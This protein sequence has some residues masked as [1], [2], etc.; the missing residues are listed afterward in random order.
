MT[1]LAMSQGH[2]GIPTQTPRDKL[3]QLPALRLKELRIDVYDELM[4]RQVTGVTPLWLPPNPSYHVRR[5]QARR[6]LSTLVLHSFRHLTLDLVFELERRFPY[7]LG[8]IFHIVDRVGHLPDPF[9]VPRNNV[10]R[11]Y[12]CVLPPDSPPPLL[13]YRAA[14]PTTLSQFRKHYEAS[15]PFAKAPSFASLLR[16]ATA[17]PPAPVPSVSATVTPTLADAGS[18]VPIPR[19][20]HASP[21]TTAARLAPGGFELLEHF[22]V[23]SSDPT[24]VVLPAALKRYNINC[25]WQ[26]Y[27]LYLVHGPKERCLG[28]EERPLVLLRQLINDGEKPLFMVRKVTPVEAEK[29]RKEMARIMGEV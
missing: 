5:N 7:L 23:S 8:Q 27:G 18:D 11:R 10:T 9:S 28:L 19:S 13:Q 17:R 4:R 14:H 6:K 12:G 20:S 24:Y 15:W 25:P 2:E 22:R 16:P 26:N 21:S 3:L 1:Y 29:T